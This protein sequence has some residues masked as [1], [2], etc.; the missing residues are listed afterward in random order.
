MCSNVFLS[1]SLFL[2]KNRF[3][4]LKPFLKFFCPRIFFFYNMCF[5]IFLC[6]APHRPKSEYFLERLTTR[7]I[8]ADEHHEH[9]I[10][11]PS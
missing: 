3:Y 8:L 6:V 11:Y 10:K 9:E 5:R 2:N 1:N 7:E 4:V